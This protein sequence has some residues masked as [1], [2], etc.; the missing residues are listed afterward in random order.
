[1]P[2]PERQLI[3]GLKDRSRGKSSAV[4]LGIGDDCAQLRLPRGQ[5]ALVTTD[6]CL[7]GVHFRR[8]WQSPECIGHRCLARGLSDI[9]A[10]GGH[11]I[12]AFL[13]I[14][15]PSGL[16]QRWVDRFFTG[17]LALADRHRVALAGGDT[18]Q[19]PD[20]VLAD[21]TVLGS[22]GR[23]LA[24]RRSGA[25]VGDQIYVTGELGESAATLQ[26]LSERK[27]RRRDIFPQP[28][29][30]VGEWL[31]TRHIA[32]AAI[33]ISDGLSTDLSH[34]CEESGVGAVIDKE[35]IPI[36]SAARKLEH[37]TE[38]RALSARDFALNLALHGGEDYELLFTAPR[39]K[40]VQRRI[41][42]VKITRIG[43]IVRGGKV[44]LISNGKRRAVIPAG[45]EHFRHKG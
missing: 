43:E 30:A 10:M 11:P 45:W 44:Y 2:L 20:R 28:R 25:R 21:I 23:N 32:S 18:A 12:A 24:L 1:M 4:L 16:P 39:S 36:H 9:G 41:A 29:I 15:L 7:E 38:S 13:S 6:L 37:Q 22:I 27:R 26:L 5:D 35:S 33:D 14:G 3:A 19:S 8:D 31:S 17:L 42:G 40:R 34:I